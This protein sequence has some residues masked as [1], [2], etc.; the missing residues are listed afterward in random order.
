MKGKIYNIPFSVPF[1]ET[2][3][4]R[5]LSQNN[6]SAFDLADM[7]FLMPNRRSCL[8]LKE[9]FLRLN[10]MTPFL[11]PKI[12]PVQDMDEDNL[13][14]ND[15][16]PDI[17]SIPQ[18]ISAEERLFLLAKMIH[19]Q[20]LEYGIEEIS[21]VQSFSLARDLC[22]LLD[23]TESADLSFENIKN[24]VPE[25]YAAHWQ[26]TLKF[27]KIVTSYW[28]EILKE[29]GVTDPALKRSEIL[30]KQAEIWQNTH[31]T[32]KIVAVGLS[33]ASSGLVSILKSVSELENGEIYIEGL[34]RFLSDKE[35]ENLSLSHPQYEKKELLK[36]LE[37]KRED[38]SDLK[39]A[40][41][42]LREK[43][44]SEMMRAP[45][46]T[47]KWRDLKKTSEIQKGL[48]GIHLIETQNSYEEAMSIALI[49]RETLQTPSKTAALV[50]TDRDL[51]RLVQNDLK[52][53]DIEIDDSAGIPLHLTPI[54]IYLR[55]I[56]NV[57]ENDF[58]FSSLLALLKNPYVSC[59]LDCQEFEKQVEVFELEVRKPSYDDQKVSIETGKVQQLLRPLFSKL[60]DLYQKDKVPF[61]DLLEAHIFLAEELASDKFLTGAEKMWRQA[62]GK[63]AANV[64]SKILETADIVGDIA[65]FEYSS[66]FAMLLSRETVRTPYGSHPRL[67]ILGPIEARFNHFDVMIIASFN[68]GVWPQTL[69]SDP[70]MSRAMK[71]KFGLPMPER[72]IGVTAND[73][74]RF[75]CADEV[76][77][78][79]SEK[80]YGTPTNKSRY[81]LRLETV[82]QAFGLSKKNI[83]NTFYTSLVQKFETSQ[84]VQSCLP[85]CPKPPKSARPHRFSSSSLTKLIENPYEIY[86]SYILG[87]KPLKDFN[88]KSDMRDF[89]NLVH[90]T[91]EK[92]IEIYPLQLDEKAQKV[93]FD[94][95]ED[96]LAN[97]DL[98]E[99]S[100]V[101]WKAR[102]EKLSVWILETEQKHR[103]DLK[104]I[105]TEIKGEIL[106][107]NSFILSARADRLEENIEGDFKIIDYK[108]GNT[109][110][111]KEVYAG[112]KPQLVLEALILENGGFQ[113]ENKPVV[114]SKPMDLIYWDLK[115]NNEIS[116]VRPKDKED[117]KEQI[118]HLVEDVKEKLKALLTAF[119]DEQTPYLYVPHPK[120][121]PSGKDYE[122]LS[123]AKEWRGDNNGN[124]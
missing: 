98:N 77:L 41:N 6:Q 56:L 94:I 18:A 15:L 54:S 52:K 12:I 3:A 92:F 78:T 44:I 114:A 33:L 70:F 57:L 95:F 30:N 17:N 47:M 50:T 80:S 38:V 63:L 89:G 11:L 42:S 108:T 71:E 117:P 60:R 112:Y 10:G 55:Q 124:Q 25:E 109:P 37:I 16:S 59:G 19:A 23:E 24:I 27:L 48:D 73:V 99:Q 2:I 49:M 74:C 43:I 61:K 115:K 123:R 90:K 62:D 84:K 87:L 101:F 85:P 26:E 107:E 68:E 82:I 7:L 20:H 76:Y 121:M 29:K 32:Q 113:T 91:L 51:A 97:Y 75:M 81:L 14:L 31:P 102:F 13:F 104:K 105:Y 36:L 35:W 69:V 116:M 93:L 111:P 119:D 58:D 34:D 9:A 88:Q 79:R 65:P 122:H 120:H 83:E 21:Y 8:S 4:E 66:L 86:A 39:L 72:S 5:F 103:Q 1:L 100:K 96:E 46:T 118:V 40:Q 110:T 22:H 67:K 64:L 106:F 53:Y 28:P 45:E